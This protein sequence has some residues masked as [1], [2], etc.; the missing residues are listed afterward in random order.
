MSLRKRVNLTQRKVAQELDIRTQTVG[1][2]EKGGV[3]HLPPSKMKKLCDIYQCTLDDL[4]EAFEKN[5]YT[6]NESVV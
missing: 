2:W 3:P 1:A 4:I 5:V 6:S